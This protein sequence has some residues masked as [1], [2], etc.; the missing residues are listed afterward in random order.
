ML[1]FK[2]ILFPVDYSPS[3]TAM[4]PYVEDMTRHFSAGL[5]LVHAY[6]LRPLF[7]NRD[8]ENVLVYS[9]LAYADPKVSEE[10]RQIE[11]ERLSEFAAQQF[12]GQRPGL[13][14]EEGEAGTVI[15]RVLQR[16]G[17]D[18]VMMPT[19]GCGPIRRFLLGSVTAKVLHDVSAGVWT[20]MG[21]A[22]E[23]HAPTVPYKSIICALDETP[24][25]EAIVRAAAALAK[26]YQANLALVHVLEMPPATPE[27]DFSPYRQDLIDA[28]HAHMRGLKD[29]LNLDVPD[30]IIDAGIAD[31]IREEIVRRKADLLLVGRGHDQGIVSRVW[32]RLYSIVRDS[33]CPV[34][35]I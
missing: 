35:S 15:H 16:Q 24:E 22:I 3:C 14:T 31:G 6:A 10:A 11:Q 13:V 19:R 29:R 8:I 21:A 7:V 27:I 25:S 33:P 30:V 32:S 12:P 20:S 28:G 18:L 5:T 1:P 34:L 17:A 9:D 23:G 2:S 26:S 4:V